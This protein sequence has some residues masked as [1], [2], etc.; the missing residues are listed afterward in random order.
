MKDNKNIFKSISVPVSETEWNGIKFH[1]KRILSFREMMEFVQAAAQLCFE[2]ETGSFIPEVKGFAIKAFMLEKYTDMDLP[3]E[4]DKKYKL[5]YSTDIVQTVQ[6]HIDGTQLQEIMNAVDAKLD[7]MANAKIDAQNKQM[8]VFYDSLER[9]E[10]Q[11]ADLFNG[12]DRDAL[13]KLMDEMIRKEPEDI[14][15]IKADFVNKTAE[16]SDTEER[17]N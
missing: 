15:L 1:I 9:M 11:L 5:I 4:I 16:I 10:A 3:A 8:K 2:S 12:L 13:S 14:K 6:K 17:L 7:Y